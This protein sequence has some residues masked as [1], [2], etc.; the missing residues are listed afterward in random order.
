MMYYIATVHFRNDRWIELQKCR[1]DRC[2]SEPFL[3]Y[4]SLEGID[5][6]YYVNFARIVPSIGGHAAKL[7]VLASAICQDSKRDDDVI[8]FLDGDALPIRNPVPLIEK[9]LQEHDL[10][11]VRRDENLGDVQPHPLFAATRVE[12][13][14]S[15]PGDWSAG[16]PWRNEV[17]DLTSD[18]G[19]NL[20]WMLEQRDAR[21]LPIL[22]TAGLTS[23]PVFFGIYGDTI[24]HH[25]AGFRPMIT[26]VDVSDCP[27]PE[28]D[29]SL[30]HALRFVQRR[31]RTWWLRRKA[32][33]IEPV[34][35]AIWKR[36]KADASFPTV[37]D[38]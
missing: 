5:S 9:A 36:L 2:M 21:W 19:G 30:P 25:G 10:V 16:Y 38:D 31:G 3:L 1:L 17:G 8:V 26:R 6:R 11:A 32:K 29:E 27:I 33:A 35:N 37:P 4:A 12:F 18:V 28:P 14:K 34:S 22:R 7:N 15:L 13:W 24:Y 20:L 23:H